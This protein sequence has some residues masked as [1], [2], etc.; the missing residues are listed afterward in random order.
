MECANGE[1]FPAI[2]IS[3]LCRNYSRV[4]ELLHERMGKYRAVGEWFRVPFPMALSMALACKYDA[5]SKYER[6]RVLGAVASDVKP[7]A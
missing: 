5:V 7:P 2:W 6:V 4:E 1:R 3:P